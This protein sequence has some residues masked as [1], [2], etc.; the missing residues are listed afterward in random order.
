MV[1]R[2]HFCKQMETKAV[3]IIFRYFQSHVIRFASGSRTR[4]AVQEASFPNYVCGL[5][6]FVPS[7]GET[8]CVGFAKAQLVALGLLCGDSLG[9]PWLL[10]GCSEVALRLLGCSEVVLTLLSGCFEVFQLALKL[11]SG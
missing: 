10:L 4:S 11:F 5:V 7:R 9:A 6:F 3:Q 1:L 8:L 2:T